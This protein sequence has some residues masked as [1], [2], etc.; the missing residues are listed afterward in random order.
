MESYAP[1]TLF[2]LTK[3]EQGEKKVKGWSL[4]D[5]DLPKYICGEVKLHLSVLQ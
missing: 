4:I 3:K 2:G 1:P 5:A